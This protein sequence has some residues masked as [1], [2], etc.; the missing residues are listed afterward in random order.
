MADKKV[1]I[2]GIDSGTWDVFNPVIER[3]KMLFLKE[4]RDAGCQGVLRSTYPPMTPPAWTSLMTGV[5][6]G[7]HGVVDWEMYDVTTNRLRY[8]TSQSIAVETMWSYLSRLGYKVASLNLPQTYPPYPVN[9]VMVSG[10]GHP[11]REAEFTYPK[12]L[13]RQILER[14]PEYDVLLRDWENDDMGDDSVFAR[15]MASSK[16]SFEN[17]YKLAELVT[18]RYGW[19]VMLVQIQQ[20]DAIL[21]RVWYYATPAGWAD[22]P[23]RAEQMFDM[24]ECLD[25]T[26]GRLTQFAEGANDLVVV[27]SDHGH[28]P[29]Y[30]KVK[31]N[32][33]LE[34]WGFLRRQD[35]SR[36]IGLRLKRNILKMLGRK[37]GHGQGSMDLIDRL[38]L[39]WSATQAVAAHVAHHGFV[40]LNVKGRQKGGLVEQG[41]PYQRL[42]SELTERFLQVR[43][44]QTGKRIFAS[45]QTPQ[46]LYGVADENS[47]CFGDLILGAADGYWPIRSLRGTKFIEP[48][49]QER[50]GGYHR[51][52]G[53]Y[54]LKGGDI[55]AGI[56]LDADIVDILPTIYA[57]IKV[58]I[59]DHLE[60]IVLEK[61]FKEPPKQIPAE[62][63]APPALSRIGVFDEHELTKTEEEQIGKRLA[64]R[65]EERR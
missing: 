34:E 38:K 52:E 44:P 10:Y 11:G 28:G 55:K 43:D 49:D 57:A 31:P 15:V 32:F 17:S 53:M 47:A 16:R 29:C 6:P 5:Y 56:C 64:D 35:S 3:G 48:Q 23:D 63:K 36:H 46:Q 30:A 37:M 20:L 18:K 1:I 22:R 12:K 50:P 2:I 27:V 59:P 65:S 7:T 42:I 9:G 4:L 8:T 24:F 14:V 13:K 54:I 26:L 61:C 62:Q 33:L 58:P 45:A 19:D 21:H 60:G 40:Y 39:D 41:E 25:N 51:R